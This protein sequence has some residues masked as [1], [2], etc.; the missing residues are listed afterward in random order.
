MVGQGKVHVSFAFA[1]AFWV[2]SFT[3][4]IINY[5]G[6]FS[7]FQKRQFDFLHFMYPHLPSE[8]HMPQRDNIS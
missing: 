5:N 2:Y 6:I 7:T 4:H 3:H 1:S 8:G